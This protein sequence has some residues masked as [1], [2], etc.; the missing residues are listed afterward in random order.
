MKDFLKYTLATI[1][2]L[3]LTGVLLFFLAFSTLIAL[4]ASSD[5]DVQ[6]KES[7]V[8]TLKL[9]GT[10]TERAIDNPLME[11]I[12]SQ[13]ST[14]GLNDILNAIRKAKTNDNIEGIY[15][16]AG[17]LTAS[18]A[19]LEA[20]RN[21]LI[22]FKT[23]DKFI[24][25]YGDQYTQGQYYIASVADEIHLNPE[26][27]VLWAGLAVQPM[28]Y[29]DLLK[30]IG[31]DMQI[32]KVGTYKSAVE[33]YIETKMSEASR[34]QTGV[35]L[36]DLWFHM[37]EGVSQARNISTD[38]LQRLANKM[39]L[40]QPTAFALESK[41]IDKLSY[42]SDMDEVIKERMDEEKPRFISFNQMKNVPITVDPK[43]KNEGDIAIYYAEGAIV[44]ASSNSYSPEIVAKKVIRDLKKL[45]DDKDIKAVVLRVNSP[46]GSAF[47]S[48]QIWKSI[49]NLKVEK[50]VVVSMGDYAASGGY[51]ISAAADLI[52]AEPTTLTGS[53]GI[54][55]MIPS[56]D[57]IAH[58][59]GLDFDVVKTNEFSDF[60]AFY[61]NMNSGEKE[62]LQSYVERGYDLFVNRC[63]EGRSMSD[64]AIRKIAEGRVWTGARAQ[65][66]GLVDK[67]GGIETAITLAAEK[68]NITEY[69]RKSYPSMPNFVEQLLEMTSKDALS[70][71]LNNSIYKDIL[72]KATEIQRLTERSPLQARMPYEFNFQSL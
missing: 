26:G 13:N 8:L 41:L 18:F 32:F 34:E 25:A 58:K 56:F 17:T 16:D 9:N 69:R 10:L 51:Y 33:P 71:Y 48:E 35:F 50:P 55:A 59:V 19:S 66:L 67:L 49:M 24:I 23:T 45:Q 68:A 44:D 15:I 52:V 38:E 62:L 72:F 22:D 28:F 36:N 42:R 6:V 1:T 12:S 27:G 60:G 3:I 61:R 47:A 53:I 21:A 5:T 11:I 40:F 20:I 39:M 30:N 14:V 54:F 7:T 63:A 70:A 57:K 29:T 64:E 2:G 43:A 65:D 37:L 31:V 4:L 46:G